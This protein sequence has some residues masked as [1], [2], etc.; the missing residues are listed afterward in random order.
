M[1]FNFKILSLLLSLFV[2][3]SCATIKKMVFK[4]R[5]EAVKEKPAE[6]VSFKPPQNYELKE[7]EELDALFWNEDQ[8]SSIS[9][10]SNC[11]KVEKSLEEFQKSSFPE[12]AKIR[13]QKKEKNQIYTILE[14]KDQTYIAISSFKKKDCLFNLNLVTPDR[15][16]LIKEEATF[17]A[18]I[19]SFN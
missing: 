16:T 7:H 18:F 15:E 10:F 11:S 4:S 1:V 2:V 17:K 12:N 14:N 3:T 9:Y 13:N 5:L 8:K 19:K 6:D